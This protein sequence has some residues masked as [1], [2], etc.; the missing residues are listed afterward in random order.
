MEIKRFN[1]LNEFHPELKVF[2][3]VRE[4][5]L[6]MILTDGIWEN[7]P[8][9]ESIKEYLIKNMDNKNRGI[10]RTILSTLKMAGVHKHDE[11]KDLF[12]KMADILEK[13]RIELAKNR[14]N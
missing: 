12:N 7:K 5:L 13:G 1:E 8:D 4:E 14:K 10:L 2:D 6:S 3:D 11:I 9:I